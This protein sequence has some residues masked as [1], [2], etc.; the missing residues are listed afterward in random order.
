MSQAHHINHL[1]AVFNNTSVL[2][3]QLIREITGLERQLERLRLRDEF[4]D[5]ST[6]QTYEEMISSRKDMLSNLPREN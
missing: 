6:L 3:Q 2:Q 4:L 5:L 1:G